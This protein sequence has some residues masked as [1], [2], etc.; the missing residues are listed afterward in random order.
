MPSRT[1]RRFPDDTV[2]PIPAVT[3]PALAYI[4]L[5]GRNAETWYRGGRRRY[6]V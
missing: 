4:R 6:P 1:S 3:N 2:P 5:H